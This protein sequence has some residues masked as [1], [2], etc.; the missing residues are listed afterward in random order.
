MVALSYLLPSKLTVCKQPNCFHA[1]LSVIEQSE[2]TEDRIR[3]SPQKCVQNSCD[4]LGRGRAGARAMTWRHDVAVSAM[5]VYAL[6]RED[7]ER[8]NDMQYVFLS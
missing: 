1:I 7:R 6:R 5:S 8:L 3:I 2:D 4:T